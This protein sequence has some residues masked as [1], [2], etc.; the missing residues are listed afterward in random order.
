MPRHRRRKKQ[1]ALV[2]GGKQNNRY[3]LPTDT[4][5]R[6]YN[7]IHSGLLGMGPAAG[8]FRERVLAIDMN[9]QR[10]LVHQVP[11][12]QSIINVRCD[13]VQPFT[14]RIQQGQRR[15]F[16]IVPIDPEVDEDDA[17]DDIGK[18]ST[19]FEKTGFQ[20]DAERE[21]DFADF[22]RM[23]IR[24]VFT[25]D[26]VAA[27][28]QYN[29]RGN[30]IAFELLD[31]ATIKRLNPESEEYKHEYEGFA[32][33]QRV[34]DK[35]EAVF[36]SDMMVLDY[37]YKRS[38]IVYR[39]YGYSPVEQCIDLIT[40]LMFGHVFS[41]DQFIKN[42]I[43]Q[44][45]LTIAGDAGKEQMDALAENWM[46]TMEG[47]GGQ[48]AIPIIASGKDGVGVNFQQL[49]QKN[50][51]MEYSKL[52][53]FLV[54]LICAV[55]SI[56]PAELGIKSDDSNNLAESSLD[57]RQGTSRDRGLSSLL[58]FI[59]KICNKI[60]QR[61]TPDFYFQFVG[62]DLEEEEKRATVAKARIG[63][64]STI[65]E[66][67][68]REGREPFKESWSQ[69]VL[70]SNVVQLINA[71]KQAEQLADQGE[72]E[73]EDQD[74]ESYDPDEEGDVID[75]DDIEEDEDVEKSLNKFKEMSLV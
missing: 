44:G 39:G 46:Q 43:P 35:T 69:I 60:L 61:I 25:I 57:T 29:R 32:F 56:D 73:E 28:I 37:Q 6:I 11:L 13:Q 55:F 52:M 8:A 2:E 45:I 53:H 18:L 48:W 4:G 65:D 15:G 40:T 64:Y 62:H 66:E 75:P 36:T 16:K 23:L 27:E 72:D 31:G 49:Q 14:N 58:S 74:Y 71:E 17:K 22:T 59:E 19:F 1:Q 51:E 54:S 3:V 5:S 24:D 21:D 12:I 41:R 63:A 42:K 50:R 34:D 38:D 33:A 68:E 67:R 47:A 9:V 30:P 10:N 7:P 70:D 26:Q 20:D